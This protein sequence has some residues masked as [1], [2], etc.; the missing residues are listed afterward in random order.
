MPGRARALLLNLGLSLGALGFG[1]LAAEAALRVLADAPRGGKEQF[2]QRRYIEHHP[3]LGWRKIPGGHA[4]YDRRDY[5]S[6]FSL[7][8]RGLRGPDVPE[9]RRPGVAR[10]L[11]LGDSFVEAFMLDDQHMLTTRT[12]V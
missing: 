9:E 10:V 8:A 12:A 5:R 11:A 3:L 4:R 7:N 6:E 1:L 2:E